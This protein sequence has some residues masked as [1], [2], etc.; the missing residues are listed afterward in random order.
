L[1]FRIKGEKLEPWKK[2][3]AKIGEELK[4]AGIIRVDS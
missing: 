3:P 2:A 1:Y 4:D